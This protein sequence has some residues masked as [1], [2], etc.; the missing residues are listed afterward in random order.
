MDAFFQR[1]VLL[2]NAALGVLIFAPF[3]LLVLLVV[4]AVRPFRGTYWY[5]RLWPVLFFASV[6][7]TVLG[8]ADILSWPW[9]SGSHGGAPDLS[10][11]ISF[12]WWHLYYAPGVAAFAAI[13][14]NQPK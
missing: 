1:F 3:V 5:G 6:I 8:G 7:W 9:G 4:F 12:L 2:A 14:I 13:S 10:L 11:L